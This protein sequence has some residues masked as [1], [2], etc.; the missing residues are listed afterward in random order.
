[1]FQRWGQAD[2]DLMATYLS[3]KLPC[4]ESAGSRS[5]GDRCLGTGCELG[6]VLPSLYFPSLP[7]DRA[8]V[9]KGRGAEGR[10][11]ADGGTLV[12]HQTMTVEV[13]RLRFTKWQVMDMVTGLS[14]PDGKRCRL[15]V[16]MISGNPELKFMAYQMKHRNWLGLHEGI[17]QSSTMALPGEDDVNTAVN[18]DFH[19]LPLL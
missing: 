4:L 8:S 5:L 14:S 6:S 16:F 2:V 15:A 10:E 12:A 18:L 7:L 19:K 11:A 1:M 3:R 9:E 17:L 13:R